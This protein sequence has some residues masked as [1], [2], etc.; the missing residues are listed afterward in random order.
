MA[1]LMFY[2]IER[3]NSFWANLVNWYLDQ[4]E[5]TEF[6]D[7]VHFFLF[8]TGNTFSFNANKNEGPKL[9]KFYQISA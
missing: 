3:K 5:Y 9:S 7:D 6:E 8:L 1:M 2:F 4:Y